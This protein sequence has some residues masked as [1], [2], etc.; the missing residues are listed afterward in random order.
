MQTFFQDLRYGARMLL[1]HRGFTLVALLTLAL[2]IGANTAIFSVVNAVLLRPLPYAE[3]E[4]LVAI[5]G[6][7][8]HKPGVKD[9]SSY[10]DFFDWRMRN[11]SFEAIAAYHQTTLTLTGAD[12]PAHLSGQVVTAELFDVLKT[13]PLLGRNFTR[14]DEKLGGAD[15]ARAA[16]ISHAL[17]Q[18][19]FGADPKVIGRALTLNQKQFQIIGVAKPGFQFPIQA[20]PVE[21]WV[22]PAEDAESL[23]GKQPVTERRGYR[24]LE[25][26]G[27]LKPGVTIAAAQAEMKLLAANLEKEYPDNNTNQSAI[28]LPFHRDLVANSRE[29]LLIL[30][31]AVSCVLLIA[32]ANVA[33]LMLAR[34]AARHKEIAVRTA[35]GA[36]RGRIIRQLLTESL[37]LSL[38]GG[39]LG[40]MLAWWGVEALLRFVP[41]GLPRLAE[42]ALDRWTLG[43]TFT[44]SMLTGVIFGLAP[45]LQASK[46]DLTEAMKDGARGSGGTTKTRLR[47]ALIVAEVAIALTLL[48]GAGLLM[49]TFL[50]L[51]RVN[52]GFDVHNVLTATVELPET[53]YATPE[54]KINF[55]R[56]L[57]QRVQALPGVTQVSAI[58]PLPI[59][60]T[61]VGGGFQIEGRKAAAGEEPHVDYRWVELDYFRTMKIPLLGGRDFTAQDSRKSAPVV[62]V[63]QAL[64]NTYFPNEDPVGKRLELP[65]GEGMK[66]QIAGVV[67]NVKHRT[68]LSRNYSPE[69]Y[70]PYAQ[71]PFLGQMSLVVR[72]QTAPGSLAKA[73]QNE[74]AALDAEIV[75]SNVKTMEQYLGAA[76][77]QPRFS[78]MLFGVFA[79]VALLLA[80]IGLYSVMAYL[81]TQRTHE[82]GI[83]LALGAQTGN[84]LR[85]ILKH[86]MTLTLLG[87][88]IGLGASFALTRLLGS[89]LYDV[90]ATDPLTFAGITLLLTTVALPA[91]YLPALQATKVDPM[92]ALRSE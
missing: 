38:G 59:S 88:A 17:W 40:L 76:V 87:V 71:F 77:S 14:A 67:Q 56:Q 29:P 82:I 19:R 20:D 21:I 47:G 32:C 62:I 15:V 28:V 52:L 66:V 30:L 8:A 23:E 42:I 13:Q 83:R 9:S 61:N 16:I 36:G 25:S 70:I 49:Q 33:N 22:T 81:V 3:P 41:E 26:V 84:V 90:S 74:V 39:L 64:A 68:E 45:A 65:F 54:Q 51:Q 72:T 79:A 24:L 31:A 44:I 4:R 58:L 50:K 7:D 48:I 5:G 11:Q 55:Y 89:L 10:P 2:G 63:N 92:I 34:A 60:N 80:A 35:L 27:R 75:L 53:Q 91:C 37:L 12:A 1:K 43:F 57:Q 46:V 6:M 86:G 78:A 69:L 85:L 73:V 18:K